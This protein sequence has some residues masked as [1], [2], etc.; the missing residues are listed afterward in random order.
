[1][2]GEKGRCRTLAFLSGLFFGL[3][4]WTRLE[5]LLY[6]LIPIVMAFC[7]ESTKDGERDRKS[8]LLFFLSLLVFPTSWF[9]NLASF[10]FSISGNVKMVGLAGVFAWIIVLAFMIGSWKLQVSTLIK[11]GLLAGAIYIVFIF[12]DNSG[13][14][15][16]WKK[17][18]IAFYR[19]LTVHGFYLFTAFLAVFVFLSKLKN[20]PSLNRLFGIFLLFYPLVHFAIFSYSSPKWENFGEYVSATFVHPGNSVNLS[21][22]RGVMSMYPLLLFFIASIPSIRKGFDD[23]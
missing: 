19:S 9:L 11:T 21:D 10:D 6:C 5:F 16:G 12:M 23:V 14:V 13:P 20:I 18:S 3:A 17:L 8:F 2:D 7:A 4:A 22:T 15:P 1:M